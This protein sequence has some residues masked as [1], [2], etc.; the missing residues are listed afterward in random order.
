MADL[1]W[2]SIEEL[3]DLIRKKEL[4]PAELMRHTLARVAELNPKL[5]AIVAMDAERAMAEA[6]KQTE[7]QASGADLGP[8]GG[9]PF[10]VKDLENLTGFVT[11]SGSPIHKDDPPADHDDIHIERLRAAGGIA[12][13][14]TN[15]PEFGLLPFTHNEVFGASRNPWDVERTPGGSSGGSSAAIASGMLAM[16]TASDGGGSIRVPA[17]YTGLYGLK[18]SHGRVPI[19]PG[20]VDAWMDTG[21]YGPLT[22]TVRDAALL[23]DV[24]AGPHDAD[25]NSLPGIDFS[26]RRRVEDDLPR[27]RIA[28]S[29]TLGVTRVQPDVAREVDAGVNAFREMGHEVEEIDDTIEDLGAW[30]AK[31]SA[32]NTVASKWELFS[33]R[34]DDFGKAAIDSMD[35]G[36]ATNPSDFGTFNRLRRELSNWTWRLF[37]RYDL[38]LTPTLPTEAFAAEG[39]LPMELDGER[40]SPIAF[41]YPF[42]F[43]G[44][45]AASVRAGLTDAGLPCGLQIVGPRHRD[46]VVLQASRMY[47]DIRP[48]V[49]VWPQL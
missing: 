26:Y 4:S 8:L 9:I 20:E 38:L 47:E 45:P 31:I 36:L 2:A 5:N 28:Y 19:G 16:A 24:M 25:R 49:G 43:T 44:H 21:V 14:K 3:A 48:W 32:W 30:W 7:R 17:C 22:R 11:T 10:G 15:T 29:R 27:L 13:G 46:D 40:F 34:H 12:I 18:P 23:L 6:T 42:N 35:R 33:T 1:N 39:P 37:E 41:T